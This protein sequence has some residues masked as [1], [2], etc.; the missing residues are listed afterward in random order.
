MKVFLG[1]Y[2][3][4]G[5]TTLN[6]NIKIFKLFNFQIQIIGRN[7]SQTHMIGKEIPNI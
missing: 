4:D 7:E 2:V 5:L 3:K 1:H 6:V